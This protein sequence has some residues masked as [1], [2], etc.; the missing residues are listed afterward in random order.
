MT[1]QIM[2][3]VGTEANPVSWLHQRAVGIIFDALAH[4][5]YQGPIDP[6]E[7]WN[8]V[9]VN[10][11]PGGPLSHDLSDG[12]SSVVVPGE[13]DNVGGI[14]PDLICRDEEGN[15]VR[16]IEV[17][18]TN[19][20]NV[21]KRQKLETLTKRGVDCVEVEVKTEEDLQNLCWV[22]A[23]FNFA[24]YDGREELHRVGVN[25]SMRE[26]RM[27]DANKSVDRLITDLLACGPKHRRQL[28]KVLRGLGSLESTW[29]THPKNP[30]RGQLKSNSGG[31]YSTN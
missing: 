12:V 5:Q 14:V 15:P 29:P 4:E 27:Q 1:S 11:R 16:I 19:S 21:A 26:R 9:K 8:Q 25:I 28:L 22:P 23:R 24:S 3:N 10:L 20:P 2:R 7:G 31:D 17:V 13:W 18:V 30:L 6:R